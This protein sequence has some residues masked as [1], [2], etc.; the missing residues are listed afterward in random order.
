MFNNIFKRI[1]FKL[2]KREFM[3]CLIIKKKDPQPSIN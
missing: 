3:L 2:G 1:A